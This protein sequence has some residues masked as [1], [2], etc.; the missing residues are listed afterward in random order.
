MSNR[1]SGPIRSPRP[2][3][4][5]AVMGVTGFRSPARNLQYCHRDE[6]TYPYHGRTRR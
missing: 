4:C 1:Q 5:N 3:A 6:G 2:G